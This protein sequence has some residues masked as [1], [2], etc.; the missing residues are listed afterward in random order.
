MYFSRRSTPVLDRQ[1]GPSAPDGLTGSGRWRRLLVAPN[2]A[3][4]GMTSLVTDVSSEMVSSVLPL[5][6]TVRLGFSALQF[7]A[8]DGLMGLATALTGLMGALL[9]DRWRRYREVA[10]T[11]YGLSATSRLGLRSA[12]GWFPILGWLTADRFGK[13]I[14][15][16]PRDALISLSAPPGRLGEAFGLHR[17]LDTGGALAG[18]LLAVVLLSVAPGSYSNVFLASFFIA[19][20][21]LA[22]LVLFVENRSARHAGT[23]ARLW[24]PLRSLWSHRLYRRVLLATALLSI[25]AVSDSFLF[26]TLR[27]RVS[28]DQRWFPIL[29]VVES[30]V[31]LVLAVPCGRLSDRLGAGRVLL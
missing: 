12:R 18:P 31:Y 30:V 29:F 11:G 13:G 14:R 23:A 3:L 17:M 22:I 9:A 26:L 10:G 6:L 4:L 8:T 20:G 2:V 24:S 27:R 21:G 16:G 7:G 1:A 25:A 28:I 5:Y 15:T 19:A